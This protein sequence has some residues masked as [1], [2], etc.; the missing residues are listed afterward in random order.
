MF[1]TTFSGRFDFAA[2][3][4]NISPLLVKTLKKGAS[5]RR[6]ST[7]TKPWYW[8]L[9]TLSRGWGDEKILLLIYIYTF[10]FTLGT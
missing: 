1:A 4:K 8:S 5:Y 6:P 10:D 2:Q 7:I 3:S 9:N